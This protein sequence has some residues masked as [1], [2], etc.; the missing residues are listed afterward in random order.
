[1]RIGV[2]V[3]GGDNA[4]LSILDGALAS[5]EFLGKDDT[6]VLV[7]D[8]EVVQPAVRALGEAGSHVEV[9]PSTQVIG[10]G[11]SPVISVRQHP[12]SSIVILARLA[13]AE[14]SAAMGREPIDAMLSAGNTGAS[15]T[16]AQMHMRRLHGVVRPGIAVTVPTFSGPVVLID[17]GANIEPKPK[18]LAQYGLMGHVYARRILNLDSPRI[19]LMNIGDEEQKGTRQLQEA[20][21]LLKEISRL[22]Y[23]GFVEGRGLFTGDA[24]VIVTDGIVGNVAIK[25]AEG[26]S[27]SL[28]QGLSRELHAL[29]PDLTHRMKPVM[30]AI[31]DRHDYHEYG[32]APLLGINGTCL[33]AHGSSEARTITNGVRCA[34]EHIRAGVNEAIIDGLNEMTEEVIA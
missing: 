11:D 21:E 16:A 24:D 9:V 4:P 26:L 1:M 30:Q 28:L 14:K 13:H 3:M 17:V 10:M 8:E 29:D 25:V 32:G 20:H 22:N 15:V 6:L 12:E 27:T 23:T 33:I 18:H 2:D 7:G 5:L 34:R 31:M 19:A